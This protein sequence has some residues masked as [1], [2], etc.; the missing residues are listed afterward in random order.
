LP[1]EEEEDG[2][3]DKSVVRQI[4]NK[5]HFIPLVIEFFSNGY[6][7]QRKQSKTLNMPG[8]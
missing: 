7:W 6:P 2:D 4:L 3:G 8:M 5:I 1:E